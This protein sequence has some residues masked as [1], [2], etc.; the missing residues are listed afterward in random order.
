MKPISR[1]KRQRIFELAEA[2][3]QSIH[4]QLSVPK[5]QAL[6]LGRGADLDAVD[7][8]VTNRVWLTDRF[9][10]IRKLDDE[11]ARLKEIAAIV[12]WTDPGPGGFYDDLGNPSRQPHLLPGESYANDPMFLR[13]PMTGI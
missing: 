9:A 10:A 5:Y 8:P 2:L 12:N 11:P 1:D 7:A 6:A 4:A 13:S 3:F